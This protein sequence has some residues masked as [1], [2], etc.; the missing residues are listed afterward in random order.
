MHNNTAQIK[1]KRQRIAGCIKCIAQTHCICVRSIVWWVIGGEESRCFRV[2]PMLQNAVQ[3]C[4]WVGANWRWKEITLLPDTSPRWLLNILSNFLIWFACKMCAYSVNVKLHFLCN[5]VTLSI[6]FYILCGFRNVDEVKMYRL[7]VVEESNSI[8]W[9]RHKLKYFRWSGTKVISSNSS[10]FF[11][12]LLFWFQLRSC[13][14]FYILFSFDLFSS[15]RFN[16]ST[17]NFKLYFWEHLWKFQTLSQTHS[18]FWFM[19]W[20]LFRWHPSNGR[21]S[22]C[23]DLAV[24][25]SSTT[26]L[27]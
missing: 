25:G 19:I 18:L 21:G 6:F 16:Y 17:R 14:L 7:S 11:R 12:A 5:F 3:I 26:R 4:C 8:L 1:K 22:E 23:V 20:S 15:S 10:K 27:N 13:W 2:L 9:Y 24:A